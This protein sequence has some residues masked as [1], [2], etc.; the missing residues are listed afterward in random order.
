MSN[1]IKRASEPKVRIKSPEEVKASDHF[2][3][4]RRVYHW[5]TSNLKTP[6]PIDIFKDFKFDVIKLL[7]GEHP[8]PPSSCNVLYIS[9]WSE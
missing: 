5:A 7:E 8:P 2:E 3:G 1:S 9:S 4:D 6:P